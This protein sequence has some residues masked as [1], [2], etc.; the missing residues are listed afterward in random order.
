MFF[1]M[2]SVMLL[3]GFLLPGVA[4]AADASDSVSLR[5]IVDAGYT[6][7]QRDSLYNVIR[8]P[9]AHGRLRVYR[10]PADRRWRCPHPSAA[11][12]QGAD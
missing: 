5:Q 7:V 9:D 3:A 1:A 8:V 4:G 2:S 11:D 6:P 10:N 12:R